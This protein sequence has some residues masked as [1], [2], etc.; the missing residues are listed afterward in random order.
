MHITSSIISLLLAS[1]T[2]VAFA[3]KHNKAK[4]AVLLSNVRSLTLQ[5]GKST[6]GRRSDS[7]PQ[8]TCVGGNGQGHYDVDVMQCKNSGSEY[9]SEDIQWTCHA[10]LPPEFK[11]GSTEVICEGYD[12]PD[13][14]HVLKGSCGVEYRL[15]LTELG[16]GKYGRNFGGNPIRKDQ[17]EE[18]HEKPQ[19]TPAAEAFRLLFWL[20]FIIVVFIIIYR[21]SG[22]DAARD[23]RLPDPPG[24]YWGGGGGGDDGNDPPP[25]YTPRAPPQPKARR[26]PS[27]SASSRTTNSGPG[28]WSGAGLGGAAGYAA[29]NYMGGRSE[30]NRQQQQNT[31]AAPGPSTYNQGGGSS[32]FGGG[33]G[34]AGPS[35]YGGGGSPSFG[36]GSSTPSSSRYES[37][38]FGGTRRR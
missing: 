34:G 8:L 28:F 5:Q 10:S 31:Y 26:G 37:T 35:T 19:M 33:G 23:L 20:V 21:I 24:G 7:L 12:S 17:K 25:P 2:R 3:E 18:V 36:G 6:T 13:D 22:R 32:W 16:E 14:Q 9:D 29:G 27:Y 15:I 1:A 30:R 4:D 11:L 38:G